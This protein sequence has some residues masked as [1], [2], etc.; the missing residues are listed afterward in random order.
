[1]D[2]CVRERNEKNRETRK[3]EQ[4]GE[5]GRAMNTSLVLM[6]KLISMMIIGAV[7]YVTIRSG[8]LEERDGKQLA[9]L[10]MY[11]LSPCLIIVAFQ[12]E[13]TAE[14]IKGYLLALIFSTLA[15]GG[16]ILVAALLRRIGLLG[17]VEELSIIYTNCGNLIL[18]IVAMTLGEE[19]V[20]YGSAYQLTYNLLF[21]THAAGKIEGGGRIDWKKA[22]LNPNI[23]AIMVGI[24]LLLTQ[25]RIPGPADTAMRMLSDMVGPASMLVIGMTMAGSSLMKVLTFKKAYLVIF[26]RLIALPLLAMGALWI[27]GFAARFPQ[28]IPVFRISF[29]AIAAPPGANV[30]QLATVYDKEPVKAGIYNLLGMICCMFTIPLIDFIYCSVFL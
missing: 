2:G 21:W 13:L 18:P 6:S 19:M 7:G 30:V 25:I 22:L 1:M 3:K 14:K 15:Q 16:F 12:V 5:Q 4:T 23:I 27:S 8:L 20:F 9:R 28:Y 29:L 24:F 26:L 11:V 10:S 17:L